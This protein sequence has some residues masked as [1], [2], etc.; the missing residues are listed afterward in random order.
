[1]DPILAMNLE[2]DRDDALMAA[3]TPFKAATRGVTLISRDG[4]QIAWLNRYFLTDFVRRYPEFGEQLSHHA[5]EKPSLAQ[6]NAVLDDHAAW[7]KF[8]SKVLQKEAIQKPPKLNDFAQWTSTLRMHPTSS[9]TDKRAFTAKPQTTPSPYKFPTRRAIS[10]DTNLGRN[11]LQ[12]SLNM[13]SPVVFKPSRPTTAPAHRKRRVQGLRPAAV[14]LDGKGML[15]QA[16]LQQESKV[17][18]YVG[19]SRTK[20]QRPAKSSLRPV[21]KTA[22]G[23]TKKQRSPLKVK[24]RMPAKQSSSFAQPLGTHRQSNLVVELPFRQ[25]ADAHRQMKGEYCYRVRNPDRRLY[26]LFTETV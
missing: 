15:D 7:N 13:S 24:I 14:T 8:K 19:N 26:G 12:R 1:V 18:E 21:E 25:P 20:E 22:H 5:I 16:G 3:A 11:P 17:S 10:L 23:N 2:R 9:L 4:C 6:M